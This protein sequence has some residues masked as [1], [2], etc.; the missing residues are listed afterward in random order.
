[1]LKTT[2][3][4]DIWRGL[5]VTLCGLILVPALAAQNYRTVR[6]DGR[7]SILGGDVAAARQ[8][9]IADAKRNALEQING[10]FI[11][12]ET[13]VDNFMLTDDAVRSV[14]NGFVESYDIR[15][16]KEMGETYLVEISARV[17]EDR[18]GEARREF[19]RIFAAV[20]RVGSSGSDMPELSRT[21]QRQIEE[22][23]VK[24]HF[25][26]YDGTR[27]S[28]AL[29]A[30]E[31]LAGEYLAEAII[32]GDLRVEASEQQ[33]TQGYL[34]ISGTL[35]FY[36]GWVDLRAVD[37]GTGKVIAV[38]TS[39]Q[40]GFK[41]SGNTPEKAARSAAAKAT[42]EIF[43]EF[44]PQITNHA[45]GKARDVTITVQGIPDHAAFT[46]VK[47]ALQN[48]R[49][50]NTVVEDKGFNRNGESVFFFEYGEKS[51]L[52][53]TKLDRL[54]NL[55]VNSQAWDQIECRWTP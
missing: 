40:A 29:M 27:R 49:F 26:V 16:E 42:N 12:S 48:V 45:R 44:L 7:A 3:K 4:I 14:V 55:E 31:Q 22:A 35:H 36:R 34:G 33:Q 11:R 23:L 52:L 18:T 10:A 28:H 30:P 39:P 24:A 54:P 17:L 51:F 43:Q 20:V 6:A 1:M 9:A 21:L 38:A 32:T 15:Q 53:A 41:A 46:A 2:M 5:L 13:A 37:A 19:M 8:E 47:T 50:R 25:T